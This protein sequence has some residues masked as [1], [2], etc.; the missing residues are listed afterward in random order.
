MLAKEQRE[1]EEE[2]AT[3]Q[4]QGAEIRQQAT[5]SVAAEETRMLKVQ[6]L[7]RQLAEKQEELRAVTARCSGLQQG[8][9]MEREMSSMAATIADQQAKVSLIFR[10]PQKPQ[11]K[12]HHHL[13][14]LHWKAAR[15]V[16]VAG[17][18]T[19]SISLYD[20]LAARRTERGI[21][22]AEGCYVPPSGIRPRKWTS[23]GPKAA[24]GEGTL[25]AGL[26]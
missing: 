14:C 20:A 10:T 21:G 9:T 13:F 23:Q 7:D 2:V 11:P 3:L 5:S 17:D 25:T 8:E 4:T 16:L 1:R 12:C 22:Q 19:P 18:Q 15:H 24:V 6:A 26:G